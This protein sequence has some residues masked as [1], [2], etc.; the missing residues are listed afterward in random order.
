MD[1]SDKEN[2][3]KTFKKKWTNENLSQLIDLYEARP[4]LWDIFCKE[5]HNRDATGKAKAE[6]EVSPFTIEN[7]TVQ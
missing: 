6:I 3:P 4:C 2:I 1:S 7:F 5:Y